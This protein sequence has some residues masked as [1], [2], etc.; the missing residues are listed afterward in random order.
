M[1]R[2]LCGPRGLKSLVVPVDV[3]KDVSRPMRAS[4]IEIRVYPDNVTGNASRPMRASWIEIQAIADALANPYASRPMRA[5]WIEIGYPRKSYL[6]IL[7]RGLCG[8]RGLKSPPDLL[9]LRNFQV[10][11]YA[12]LV[13]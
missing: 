8:P 10:E 7:R 4:W 9:Y 6:P 12:G 2:G 3:A 1:C 11:A 13:D 5:S